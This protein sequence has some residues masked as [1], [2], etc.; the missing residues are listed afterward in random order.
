MGYLRPIKALLNQVF[1]VVLLVLLLHELSHQ[2]DLLELPIGYYPIYLLLDVI[3][4]VLLLDYHM[5]PGV[6]VLLVRSL[7]T[8]AHIMTLSHQDL[9]KVEYLKLLLV[10][11]LTCVFISILL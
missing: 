1:V 5:L 8:I 3:T 6:R 2:V 9:V 10:D 11:T 4:A 7:L